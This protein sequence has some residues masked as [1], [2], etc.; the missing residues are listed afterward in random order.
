M[1]LDTLSSDPSANRGL[2]LG[3]V[4]AESAEGCWRVKDESGRA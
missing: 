3:E 2:K 1:S 4:R